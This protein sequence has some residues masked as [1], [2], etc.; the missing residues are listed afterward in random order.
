M[1]FTSP[2]KI[3]VLKRVWLRRTSKCDYIP[4]RRLIGCVFAVGFLIGIVVLLRTE[5]AASL[6]LPGTND[7]LHACA[8]RRSSAARSLLS[9]TPASLR[10][11]ACSH[12]L[13]LSASSSSLPVCSSCPTLLLSG[14]RSSCAV[15]CLGFMPYSRRREAI[16]RFFKTVP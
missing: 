16:P 3:V 14:A 12:Q 13:C 9:T 5:T 1:T 10:L 15:N 6:Q 4:W 8:V 7:L 11:P 2:C